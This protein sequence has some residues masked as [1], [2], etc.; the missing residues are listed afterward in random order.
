LSWI[1]SRD[2]EPLRRIDRRIPRDLET[3]VLKCLRKEPADRYRT[4]EALAQDLRRF[5]KGEA[6]EAR[7]QAGWE[8][9]ARK[10]RR[11]RHSP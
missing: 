6:I 2:P 5:A 1:I 3:I 4:A 10:V 8:R 9:I 7:P 11:V